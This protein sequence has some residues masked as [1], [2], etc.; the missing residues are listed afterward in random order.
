M[1]NE[2]NAYLREILRN[3]GDGADKI[4]IDFGSDEFKYKLLSMIDDASNSEYVLQLLNVIILNH[5]FSRISR[6]FK[7]GEIY[8]RGEKKSK[9]LNTES[10][11]AHDCYDIAGDVYCEVVKRLDTFIL[12]VIER[13]YDEKARQ[14]WL[15]KIIYC[16]CA[17]HL[18]RM[19]KLSFII[20]NDDDEDEFTYIPESTLKSPEYIAICNDIVKNTITI[21]CDAPFKP[22]KILS[23]LYNVIIFKEIEGRKKNSSSTTTCEYMNGKIL[24]TLK[25][26]FVPMFNQTYAIELSYEDIDNLSSVLGYDLATLKGKELF[27][28]TPKL[29]TDWTNRVKTYLYKHKKNLL[30]EEGYGE[31]Y[32]K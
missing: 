20:D 12:N 13:G 19:G 24:F 28:A 22:E 10:I 31:E 23:Y 1:D 17:R 15:R 7:E 16:T 6:G 26:N 30:D 3:I 14:A 8:N 25:E 21:V 18:N 9:S 11:S 32:A 5:T 29:V 2:R 4:N 27:N